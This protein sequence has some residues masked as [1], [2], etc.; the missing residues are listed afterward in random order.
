MEWKQYV[1]LGTELLFLGIGTYFDVK[2]RELPWSFLGGFCILGIFLNIIWKYQ[3]LE[4]IF[5]GVLLAGVFLLIGKFSKEALG[6]GDGFSVLVLGILNGWKETVEL[7]FVAL[8]ISSVYGI[9]KMLCHG[10]KAEDAMP[11][12]PF[13][14]LAKMGEFVL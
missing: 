10:A 13:L 6:Y 11:F 7:L 8:L 4:M 5:G 2:S 1:L 14:L 3:T 9:W 12:F